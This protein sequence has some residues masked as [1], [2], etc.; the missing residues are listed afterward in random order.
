MLSSLLLRDCLS[1]ISDQSISHLSSLSIMV[2]KIPCVHVHGIS[3]TLSNVIMVVL[4]S[5]KTR[6]EVVSSLIEDTSTRDSW[7]ADTMGVVSSMS[8]S[9]IVVIF[10][11]NLIKVV[12]DWHASRE[13]EMVLVLWVALHHVHSLHV[14]QVEVMVLALLNS[15]HESSWSWGAHW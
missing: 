2:I 4:V 3:V 12:A 14:R 10:L 15:H 5:N 8:L 7:I 13:H 9:L 6:R 1:R 11:M